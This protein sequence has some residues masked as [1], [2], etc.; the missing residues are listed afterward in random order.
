MTRWLRLILAFVVLTAASPIAPAAADGCQF[1]LG[2]KLIHDTIPGMVGD[3]VT[4]EHFNLANGDSIQ[5]VTAWH[6]KGGLLVW[7]KCDNWTAFTDGSNTWVNGPFGV[8]MR[9]NSDRFGFEHDSC[10]SVATATATA[11]PTAVP[12][13]APTPFPTSVPNL[14][15]L[16]TIVSLNDL[17]RC[18]LKRLYPNGVGHWAYWLG[19]PPAPCPAT[20]RDAD[21]AAQHLLG[22][23]LAID[24]HNIEGS[25]K[26][27]SG[28]GRWLVEYERAYGQIY[29]EVNAVQ[30]DGLTHISSSDALVSLNYI[31]T[32][33]HGSNVIVG[34]TVTDSSWSSSLAPLSPGWVSSTPA[35]WFGYR[36]VTLNGRYGTAAVT[37]SF[38]ANNPPP[39]MSTEQIVVFLYAPGQE[40]FYS[41]NFYFPYQ[42]AR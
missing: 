25:V 4:N 9:P 42:W 21:A 2:F 34:A 14:T 38:S 12:T 30:I 13:I 6:G 20:N 5:D 28:V 18:L 11:I 3:C 33:D 39:S 17:E 32:G 1:V 19:G 7:R 22:L 16:Q 41:N 35:R 40:P 36:P 15:I 24:T 8:Q 37:I 23:G 29:P 10:V 26:L 31:Y 27:A